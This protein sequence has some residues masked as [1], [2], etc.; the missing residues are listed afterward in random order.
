[1]S[2]RNFLISLTVF[3]I[4]ASCAPKDQKIAK[5]DSKASPAGTISAPSG[6]ADN[7]KY[8]AILLDRQMEV[9]QLFKILTTPEFALQKGFKVE[10]IE[11]NTVKFKKI[12]AHLTSSSEKLTF[13]KDISLLAQVISDE[14][15]KILKISIVEDANLPSSESVTK[16]ADNLKLFIKNKTTRLQIERSKT[17]DSVSATLDTVDQVEIKTAKSIN[18]NFLKF[19]FTSIATDSG[20]RF[21]INSIELNHS[22]YG[23]ADFSLKST[24]KLD[25]I[26]QVDPLCTSVTGSLVL[27][28][29]EV[30]EIKKTPPYSRDLKYQDSSL[31]LKAGTDT[32][33]LKAAPCAERP[34]VDIGKLL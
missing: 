28:S 7:Y 4:L 9:L 2:I 11:I 13:V 16:T 25:L 17:D 3:S 26:V 6:N 10:D 18:V 30:D 15:G 19:N 34:I 14:S 21:K 1:M 20:E 24:D 29:V 32:Y 8:M 31:I 33:D 27:N 22:R 12:T 5:P 23:A